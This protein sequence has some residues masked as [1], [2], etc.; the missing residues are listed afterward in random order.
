MLMKS[1]RRKIQESKRIESEVIL[2]RNKLDEKFVQSKFENNSRTL[3]DILS[4]QLPLNDKTRLGYD[5]QKK[6]KCLSFTFQD[7]DKRSYVATLKSPKI[8]QI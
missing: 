7:R 1:S 2:L 3:D 8:P 4:S 5:K 6:P